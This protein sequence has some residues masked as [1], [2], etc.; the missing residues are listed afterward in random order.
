MSPL[1]WANKQQ[2]TQ[3][4]FIFTDISLSQHTISPTKT[5]TVSQHH[6]SQSNLHA[7]TKYVRI[8]TLC[9]HR[10]AREH[11]GFLFHDTELQLQVHTQGE[12]PHYITTCS[13]NRT[14]DVVCSALSTCQRWSPKVV[15]KCHITASSVYSIDCCC[16]TLSENGIE[17]RILRVKSM[18]YLFCEASRV[19]TKTPFFSCK[20]YM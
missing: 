7:N 13:G 20:R 18:I 3:S 9:C 5:A 19:C 16:F 6:T 2:R 12:P 4:S 17:K 14:H 10:C 11:I 8:H 15:K 1:L